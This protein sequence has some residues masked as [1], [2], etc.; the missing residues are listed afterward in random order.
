MRRLDRLISDISNASR[1]DAELAR[2]NTETVDL[3]ELAAAIVS[4]QTDLAAGRDVAVKL[5][6]AEGRYAPLVKGHDTRLAQVF[7]NLIDNAVSFSP[8]GGTVAV[9]ITATAD[10]IV[11]TVKDEG[12]GLEGDIEKVFQRFY[13]DRPEGESFGDHSGLGLSISRQIAQAH[14][15]TLDAGNRTDATGAVFTLTLPRAK[16]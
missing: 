9:T 10:D 16:T 8:A 6:V 13:T 2:E 15:G 5:V 7:T 4:I 1:I 3:A 11:A 12:P 14:Q